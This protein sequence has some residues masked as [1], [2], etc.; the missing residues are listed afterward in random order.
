MSLIAIP[1][2]PDVVRV[3]FGGEAQALAASVRQA[4]AAPA[5]P[6]MPGILLVSGDSGNVV[7][8]GKRVLNWKI[9][10]SNVLA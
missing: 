7:K 1:S 5:A 4:L 2:A 9:N 8:S 3:A 6:F 10:G